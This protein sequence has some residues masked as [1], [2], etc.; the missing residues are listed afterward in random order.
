MSVRCI[1]SQCLATAPTKV[2]IGATSASVSLW[3]RLNP[4]SHV[5]VPGGTQLFGDGAGR[6]SIVLDG[7]GNLHAGWFPDGVL[8]GG[9]S[10][11]SRALAPGTSHHLAITWQGGLQQYYFDGVL[12]HATNLPGSL[13]S[14]SKAA[15]VPFRLG[16]DSSGT[17]VTLDEPAVWVGYSLSARDAADLSSRAV[18]PAGIAPAS[19]VARWTLAGPDGL[20][21]TVGDPGL[22][23]A[24]A[25]GLDL[26]TV[27]GS[28]PTYQSASLSYS[29]PGP[30]SKVD[31]A[32][33]GTAIAVTALDLQGKPSHIHSLLSLDDLQAIVI[34][35]YPAGGQVALSWNGHATAPIAV[36]DNAPT[37]AT[38]T[39]TGLVPGKQYVARIAHYANPYYGVARLNLIDGAGHVVNQVEL[40]L[41]RFTQTY[42]TGAANGYYSFEDIATFAATTPTLTLRM[43]GQGFTSSTYHGYI[44]AL[45]AQVTPAG[46]PPGNDPNDSPA[47]IQD[48]SKATLVGDWDS[49]HKTQPNGYTHWFTADPAAIQAAL[50]ALP[51]IPAGGVVVTN[52]ETGVY[53]VRFAGTLAATAQPT[54]TASD[55]AV[56]V[57]HDGSR[58]SAVGGQ[59][60]SIAIN[61]G[62]SIAL[63]Q[64]VWDQSLP[65]ALYLLPGSTTVGPAD[66][67]TFSAPAGFVMS[68]AG[69]A[70]ALVAAPATNHAGG[71]LIP[72][73][74]PTTPRAMKHGWNLDSELYYSYSA[75][76][77]NLAYRMASIDCVESNADFYPTKLAVNSTTGVSLV[78]EFAPDPGGDGKG[79]PVLPMGRYTVAWDGASDCRIDSFG[80][81]TACV[82]DA[83][84][85]SFTGGVNNHREFMLSGS[86]TRC[87][88]FYLVVKRCAD[89]A[90]G[91]GVVDLKNLRIYPPDPADPTGHTAWRN[92]PKFHPGLLAQLAG[93]AAFRTMNPLGINDSNVR[94]FADFPTATQLSKYVGTAGH[95]APIVSIAPYT[96]H[97]PF[98]FDGNAVALVTTSAPH[99]LTDGTRVFLI[100]GP[101]PIGQLTYADGAMPTEM[102]RF[103]GITRVLTPT[104]FL[105]SSYRNG[106]FS[107]TLTPTG[108]TAQFNAGGTSGIAYTDLLDL[109]NSANQDI[110]INVPVLASDACVAKMATLAAARLHP[111]RKIHLEFSNEVWNNGFSQWYVASGLS[112]VMRAADKSIPD[113]G[114]NAQSAWYAYRMVQVHAAFR[115]AWVAAGRAAA[116]VRRVMGIQTASNDSLDAYLVALQHF[117]PTTWTTL[118][119]EVAIAPY[120]GNNPAP[121]WSNQVQ[122][123]TDPASPA[124]MLDLL[125]LIA[126]HGGYGT[127]VTQVRADLDARGMT[128]A[129]VVSYEGG[130]DFLT[131]FHQ[132]NKFPVDAHRNHIIARHPRFFGIVLKMLRNFDDGG[133]KLFMHFTLSGQ[134]QAAEWPAYLYTGQAAGTGDA[135]RDLANVSTPFDASAIVSQIGGAARY[136]SSLVAATNPKRI[137]PGRNGK[138]KAWGLSRSAR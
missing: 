19:I 16:S 91:T 123:I 11:W 86:T 56:T 79:I 137:V 110:W 98:F 34:G 44:Q 45:A 121:G 58:G 47:T 65:C 50:L 25:S 27:V 63:P 43:L 96:G 70:P 93:A 135:T 80:G 76:Y 127:W 118:V 119:D 92:P 109:A 114:Y 124:Q 101:T 66:V 15:A 9:G 87:P 10:S 83:S 104:T 1:G 108:A 18:H 14:A 105:I 128:G 32:P 2:L 28:S 12:A 117:F 134:D 138:T 74:N 48:F 102:D 39:F 8:A 35:D 129:D 84:R 130:A 72:A 62:P 126:L 131:P 54:L 4:G 122:P 29:P 82:E 22:R 17:D 36:T 77:T 68:A 3:V 38:W 5:S 116:D 46:G 115:A 21:A 103:I 64:P 136:W 100:P 33:S 90:D 41:T 31:V 23:D 69:P 13:G 88:R 20:K 111:G 71:S 107:N 85:A 132:Y 120:W 97:D 6:V 94:E 75:H 73:S 51:G 40:D 133:C 125:E 59:Y 49:Q 30:S 99:S 24:S 52:P 106:T 53:L 42:G 78:N 67:V 55:P 37:S 57:V 7:A 113:S 95:S 60:P 26:A 61:G 89:N 112:R 81:T